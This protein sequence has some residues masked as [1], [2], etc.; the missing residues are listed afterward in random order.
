MSHFLTFIIP[1]ALQDKSRKLSR[2]LHGEPNYEMF[3]TGLSPTG[4]LPATHYISSGHAD[5]NQAADWLDHKVLKDS[6]DL[7]KL[8]KA[9]RK[10]AKLAAKAQKVAD[11]AAKKAANGGK[12]VAL[13][14]EE[15]AADAL[16]DAEQIILNEDIAAVTI[17]LADAKTHLSGCD[18]S[19]EE[20]P[21]A[22]ARLGLQVIQGTL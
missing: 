10:A 13:T 12:A 22:V 11:R 4:Q 6:A 3:V 8:D 19:E 1:A 14:P 18:I 5:D 21:V 20:W 17:T 15:I 16:A 7:K 2:A 9:D